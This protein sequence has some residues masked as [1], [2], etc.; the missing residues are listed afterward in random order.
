MLLA[1]NV[2]NVCRHL[3][4]HEPQWCQYVIMSHVCHYVLC[5][6]C[7]YVTFQY[8]RVLFIKCHQLQTLSLL[9]IVDFNH[10]SSVCLSLLVLLTVSLV[11]LKN[12]V[13]DAKFRIVTNDINE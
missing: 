6:S 13:Y 7:V 3:N 5:M 2:H 4:G 9:F 1:V 10:Q 11:I 12:V 8:H